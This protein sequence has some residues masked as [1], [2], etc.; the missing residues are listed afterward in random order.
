MQS[1]HVELKVR[2]AK[3]EKKGAVET[4]HKDCYWD[5]IR[6]IAL[7]PMN[8]LEDLADVLGYDSVVAMREGMQV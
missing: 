2:I 6:E 7:G 1:E 4:M 8:A 3:A 5:W